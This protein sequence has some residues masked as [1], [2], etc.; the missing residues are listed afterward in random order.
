MPAQPKDLCWGVSASSDLGE[1]PQV[2]KC[3]AGNKFSFRKKTEI[4]D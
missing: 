4:K 3:K 2:H 1:E